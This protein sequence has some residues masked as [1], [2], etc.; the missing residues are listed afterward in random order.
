MPRQ[1][2]TFSDDGVETRE[3]AKR[4]RERGRRERK[5]GGDPEHMEG[6]AHDGRR[7]TSA[8]TCRKLVESM[9]AS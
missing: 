3:A 5:R 8:A 9:A 4:E 2:R 7:D 6:L 1:G